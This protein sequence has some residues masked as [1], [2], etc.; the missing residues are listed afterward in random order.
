[1]NVFTSLIG[2]TR[3]TKP[4]RNSPGAASTRGSAASGSMLMPFGTT[5]VLAGSAPSRI[6]AWRLP[7]KIVTMR[8]AWA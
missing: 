8:S 4:M 1:M 2:T 7:S 5:S 6:W 3:P